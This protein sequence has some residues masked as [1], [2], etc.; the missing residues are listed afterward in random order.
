MLLSPS[1]LGWYTPN[2]NIVWRCMEIVQLLKYLRLILLVSTS[3]FMLLS[4]ELNTRS[5]KFIHRMWFVTVMSLD[6]GSLSSPWV[7][8]QYKSLISY[9]LSREYRVEEIDIHVFFHQWR[10]DWCR[11]ARA[12]THDERGVTMSIPRLSV[13]SQITCDGVTVVSQKDRHWWQ[14]RNER[15]LFLLDFCIQYMK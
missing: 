7:F 1:S 3:S 11:L 8:K 12:R 15:S 6:N 9:T 13:T 5:C 2:C 14:W 4:S 10:S